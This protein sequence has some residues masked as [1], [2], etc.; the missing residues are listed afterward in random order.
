MNVLHGIHTE[1]VVD[2]WE[3]ILTI[4]SNLLEILNTQ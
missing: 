2:S 4:H 3:I 1:H